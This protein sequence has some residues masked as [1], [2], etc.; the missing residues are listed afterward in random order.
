MTLIPEDYSPR[1]VGDL[2]QDECM[3]FADGAGEPFHLD[4][5]DLTMMQVTFMNEATGTIRTG[6]GTF[7]FVNPDDATNGIV[8]YTWAAD[9]VALAGL[10]QVQVA[11]PFNSLAD[12]AAVKWQH[13]E[14][15]WI[16]WETPLGGP[17]GP[18]PAPPGD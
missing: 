11:V 6:A 16:E 3:Q 5:V 18:P 2:A 10:F 8:W 1:Y 7:A 13:F 4:T 17:L 15:K 9:D 12:Q 14:R